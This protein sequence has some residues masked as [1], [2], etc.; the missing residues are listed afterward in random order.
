MRKKLFSIILLTLIVAGLC[1][2]VTAYAHGV[3]IE[4]KNTE[5]IE[6]TAKFD[7]GEPMSEAQVLVYAPNDPEN[8]WLTGVCDDDGHFSFIPDVS[9]PGTWD[10]QVR[11]AGH[12]DMIHIEVE[13]GTIT[14][15]SSSELSTGQIVLM[16]VCVIWG[17]A[18]TGLYFRRRRA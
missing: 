6:I 1:L 16:S 2:P 7:T 15:G 12:G 18:G 3:D 9:I 10:I 14:G 11:K 8:V 17:L 4:F 5:T 13:E